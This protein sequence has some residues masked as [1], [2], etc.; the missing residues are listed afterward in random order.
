MLS[1]DIDPMSNINLSAFPSSTSQ[2][3][4]A[5]AGLGVGIPVP[6]EMTRISSGAS[7]SVPG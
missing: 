5:W 1:E 2:Q 4:A 7:S 3:D 6:Q